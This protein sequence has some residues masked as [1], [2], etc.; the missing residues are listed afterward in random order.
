MV[1]NKFW[2]L[3]ICFLFNISLKLRTQIS[4][5]AMNGKKMGFELGVIPRGH[6]DPRLTF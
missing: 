2:L 3:K 4:I 5:N 6:K 1:V